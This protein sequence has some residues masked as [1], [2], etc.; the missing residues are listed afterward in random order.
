MSNE[1]V[2]LDL[3]KLPSTQLGSDAD[4]NDLARSSGFLP[5]LILYTKGKAVNSRKVSPG[6][7]GV[8]EKGEEITRLGDSI[9][10][11]V[12]ARRPKALD[13]NDT[14]NIITSYDPNSDL[15]QDIQQRS[16]KQNSKCMYGPSF[17]VFERST[18]QFLE[19]FC[20]T[21]S[22]RGEAGK[23]YPFCPV[24]PA[25]IEAKKAAG[26]DVAGMVPHGPR[27][28]TLKTRMVEKGDFSWHVPVVL[29]CSTPFT[30]LPSAKEVINQIQAFINVKDSNPEV[31][32]K[33]E[34]ST[35]RAR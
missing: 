16:A 32:T 20:G 4:Y 6:E 14:D 33:E 26:S 24:T 11:L 3:T 21:K 10:V 27:A 12:L 34:A 23:L 15:F 5:R 8:P 25:D 30:N 17:L 31:V 2:S 35:R 28:A 9:D 19:Y 18:G 22:S 1:L 13:L 29:P 7:W